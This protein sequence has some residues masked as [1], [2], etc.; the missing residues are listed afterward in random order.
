MPIYNLS[1]LI[2]QSHL[3]EDQ[4]LLSPVLLLTTCWS[5]DCTVLYFYIIYYFNLILYGTP[6]HITGY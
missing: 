4:R 2:S 5:P 3:L 1:L 6:A